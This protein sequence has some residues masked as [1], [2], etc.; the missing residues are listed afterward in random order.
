MLAVYGA[1]GSAGSQYRCVVK[2]TEGDTK[3]TLVYEVLIEHEKVR[4]TW[5]KIKLYLKK[6]YTGP[7]V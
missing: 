1:D 7:L 3:A 2:A 4:A 5:R 6:G